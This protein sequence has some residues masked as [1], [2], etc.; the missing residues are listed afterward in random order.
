LAHRRGGKHLVIALF[1][2]PV[3]GEVVARMLANDAGTGGRPET[4]GMLAL[5]DDGKIAVAKLGAR[6]TAGDTGVGAVLGMIAL[7]LSGGVM[8]KRHHFFDA[9]SDLSTDDIARLGAELE[10]GEAAVAI[11]DRR[12]QAERA[13]VWLTGLGGRTEVHH[14]TSGALRQAASAPTILA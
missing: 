14:L 11:L 8:P 2:N 7:A 13:V 9:S 10:A 6:T 3:A 4:V 12:P 5:E 1:D